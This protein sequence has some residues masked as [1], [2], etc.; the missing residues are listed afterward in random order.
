M[1]ESEVITAFG[2]ERGRLGFSILRLMIEPDKNRWSLYVPRA[3]QAYEMGATIIASPWYAPDEM[4]EE[5]NGVSRVKHDM[6]EEYAAHL[7][8]FN[9]FMANNGVPVYGISI[10]NE[11]DI[12]DQWTSWT[13]SEILTFMKENAHAITGTKVM[14]PESF[15]FNRSYSD[16]ILNDS[17][18]C[19]N[20]DIIC[21]HIYGS[22]L[23]YYPLAEQKGKEVWMTEYLI[24]SGNPPTNLDIDTGWTGAI[25]TAVNINN[26]MTASMNAYVWWY[27]VRYYG[28]IADGTY[29]KKGEV[30]KKGYV[31]SQFARFIRP[32]DYR[33]E[34]SVYPTGT[35]IYISAYVDSVS[36]KE[37][38][39]AINTSSLPKDVAFKVKNL[40]NSVFTPYT[41]SEDKIVIQGEDI[42]IDEDNIVLNLEGSSITT[43]V[44]NE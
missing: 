17:V 35:N 19:A 33:T 37:V 9:T 26:C 28:P 22:G 16:P 44:S 30:T 10:Q 21:G 3:K 29:T 34:S 5:V 7:D 38:I 18:A 31:M 43:F 40:T 4:T 8:S 14:A 24:N 41:T 11:P 1:T 6:Y 32:G 42:N 15:H 2:T 39:V 25:Q 13:A 12:T 36:S 27:I 23:S 20:T